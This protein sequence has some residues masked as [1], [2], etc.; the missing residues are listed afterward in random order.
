[1]Q[2][3]VE[4]GLSRKTDSLI[5]LLIYFCYNLKIYWYLI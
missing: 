2:T 1:M 4:L 5:N 3:F